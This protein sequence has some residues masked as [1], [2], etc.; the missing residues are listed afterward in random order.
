MKKI[1]SDFEDWNIIKN[2]YRVLNPLFANG[3]GGYIL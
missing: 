2:A 1:E 3:T